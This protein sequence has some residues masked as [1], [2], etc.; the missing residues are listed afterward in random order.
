MLRV[1]LSVAIM[2]AVGGC[3]S[4]QDPLLSAELECDSYVGTAKV[5]NLASDHLIIF[6]EMHGTN[7][8]PE[9]IGQLACS[10]LH[11]GRPV[12]IG[13][14]ADWP[15]GASL[16][17]A[18]ED[19]FDREVVLNAAPKMWS[20]Y[21]GRSSEAVLEL[22]EQVSQWYGQ[23]FDISV[24]AFDALPSEWVGAENQ[25]IARDAAMAKQ[26]N[27]QVSE[28]DGA[29]LLQT[30]NFHA[31][32]SPFSF[33]DQ[34]FIP[35]ASLITV[36]PVFSLEMKYGPGSAWVN[37]T[38]EDGEGNIVEN[39][40]PMQMGGIGKPDAEPR[41]FVLENDWPAAFDG[42]YFTGSISASPPAFPVKNTLEST[43]TD[44]ALPE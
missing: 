39:L 9:A 1:V 4:Q 40:G 2:L 37:A 25:A 5:V 17:R 34:A 3:L 43:T 6:G 35:M 21:D 29:V 42:E 36:R 41:S 15:Q 33:A 14:E 44:D 28:F 11:S 24:F 8:S 32:K 38:Y 7:E 13:L 10:L 31:Q 19:P 20:T 30:G 18:I 26:V 23:G 27:L 12:R 16:A 22:L